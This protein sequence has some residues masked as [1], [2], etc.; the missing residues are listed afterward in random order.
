MT[1]SPAAA[2]SAHAA[3]ESYLTA[4]RA[5]DRRA[6]FSAVES[7]RAAGLDIAAI[8][9]DV[10][11]PALREIGLLWQQNLLT[12]ADEHL[13][14]AVTMSAMMRLA[15]E[16]IPEQRGRLTMI[17][18]CGES[19]RH[20]I[21][22]RMLCDLLDREGWETIFLGS[23]VPMDSLARMVA[24]RAPNAVALSAS[25]APHLPNLRVAIRAVRRAAGDSQ[26]LILVGGR[27]FIDQPGLAT[28]AG[29]DL[30]ANDA[31]L[32]VQL[33]VEHFA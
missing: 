25:L 12:V 30:T 2:V 10:L 17:A 7:A 27:L 21:G 13:A 6:A 22:L 31:A 4:L 5:G 15:A 32:A 33:L 1:L 20:E 14:T 23:T 24:E 18:A 26:P 16:T 8:Y 19:E 3:Y 28:W 9:L 11:Q 29:A